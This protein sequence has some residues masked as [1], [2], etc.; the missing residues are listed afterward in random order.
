[1]TVHRGHPVTDARHSALRSPLAEHERDLPVD[2]AWLRRRAK[3]FAHVSQR[4][5]H[6]VVDLQAYAS[7]TG[8]PF[9]AHYAAQ[10]YRGP[11]SA[12][13]TVPLMA[14]NLSLVTTREEA[15]RALA[16]ETMHLV[17]PSYG[18]KEAAFARAQLLLDEVG[19]LTVA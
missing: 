17:V 7:V 1:M 6:L 5:F 2:A 9:Y 14:V 12:R 4:P 15:D 3:Q 19:Q 10:V 18:H 8:L 13:L 16:H 11:E